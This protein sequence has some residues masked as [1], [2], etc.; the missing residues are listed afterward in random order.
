MNSLSGSTIAEQRMNQIKIRIE[1]LKLLRKKYQI[2]LMK[3]TGFTYE[4]ASIDNDQS[5]SNGGMNL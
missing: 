2:E 5:I 4:E 3:L 1:K